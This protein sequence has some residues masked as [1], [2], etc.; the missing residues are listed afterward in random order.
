VTKKKK[1][2]VDRGAWPYKMKDLCS[3]TGMPRQAIHFYI[4]EGLVPEGVKTGRNMAYYGESHVERIRFIRQLQ[5]ERFLPLKAIRAVL[6]GKDDAFDPA[7]RRLLL[8]VKRRLP[9]A[10]SAPRRASDAV[11]A[12]GVLART[13]L[14]SKDLAEMAKIGL[15]A[16]SHGAHGKTQ[17]AKDD[18]WILELWGE[19][20]ALGFTRALGFPASMLALYEEGVQS[21]F[22]REVEILTKQ[23]A[24]LP[25][26]KVATMVDRVQP[27][28]GTFLA[29]YHE[30][31]IR[32]FFASM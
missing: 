23:L 31:K 21:I 22:D 9:R 32:N 14:D 5:H 28:I 24:K 8:D 3:L 18:I 2:G 25:P 12:K 1:T 7:Q 6:E 4:Q 19:V 29:R 26:D 17:I 15:V 10:L 13:G 30:A 27:L 16:I 20:R 11:D